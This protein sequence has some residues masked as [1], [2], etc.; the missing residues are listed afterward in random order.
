[1]RRYLAAMRH[2]LVTHHHASDQPPGAA[3]ARLRARLRSAVR[4]RGRDRHR[5][6]RSTARR[7]TS[8]WT[9]RSRAG[10]SPPA[11]RSSIDSDCHRADMLGRQMELG[12]N[13]GAP[14]LGRAAAR[15]EHAADRR[16]PRAHRG[17]A[18]AL[19]RWRGALA[20]PV[21]GGSSAS[22]PSRSTARRCCPASTS[23]TPPSFQVMAGSPTITPRDGYP[24]YFAIGACSSGLTRG[25]PAHALNLASAAAAAVACGLIVLRGARAVGIAGGRGRRRA[26]LRRLV[27]VLEPGVIAEVYALHICLVAADA[28]PAAALGAAAE[29]GAAGDLLRRLRRW[30]SA[31]TCR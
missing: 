17:E 1:M 24:L 19:T 28:A 8:I 27:H 15:D 21:V 25:D 9:A 31:I 3:S 14:R 26:R 29:P 6:R 12:V 16:R 13:D 2:P 4:R 20:Q 30:R 18:R 23:A 10:R 22:P 11:P 7:R 5:G